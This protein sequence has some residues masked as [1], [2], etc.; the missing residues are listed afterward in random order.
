MS[1]NDV[2]IQVLKDEQTSEQ[3]LHRNDDDE[4]ENL[5]HALVII[6]R[7]ARDPEYAE[8]LQ[9]ELKSENKHS[10]EIIAKSSRCREMIAEKSDELKKIEKEI[11]DKKL[12][13]ERLQAATHEREEANRS[14]M[15]KEDEIAQLKR[16][17]AVQVAGKEDNRQSNKIKI[18]AR[19]S[20][21]KSFRHE[22]ED[23]EKDEEWELQKFEVRLSSVKLS[24]NDTCL[25]SISH[26]Y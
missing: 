26:E 4:E 7:E 5:K 25:A 20:E 14:I 12:E 2:L 21:K 1:I 23:E 11:K 6:D 15:K 13:L 19:S 8:K 16:A 22:L 3:I 10:L 9:E 24:M 17:L 18:Q